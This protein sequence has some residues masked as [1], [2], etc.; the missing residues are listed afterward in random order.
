MPFLCFL[1]LFLVGRFRKTRLGKGKVAADKKLKEG[2]LQELRELLKKKQDQ[3]SITG[4]GRKGKQGL[5]KSSS[6]ADLP[7]TGNYSFV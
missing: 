4:R 5:E 7:Y 3:K 6:Q 2:K 1:L